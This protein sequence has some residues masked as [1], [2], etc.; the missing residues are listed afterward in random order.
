MKKICFFV[1]PSLT[2]LSSLLP[3]PLSATVIH[4]D[5]DDS[6]VADT[7]T[8]DSFCTLREA[9]LAANEDSNAGDDDCETGSGDDE[10]ILLAGTYTLALPSTDEDLNAD[11]DLDITANLTITGAGADV[12][13]IDGGGIDR[14]FHIDPASAGITVS[15][16]GL[17]VTG[18]KSRLGFSGGGFLIND[19]TVNLDEMNV[20]GNTTSDG[21]NGPIG[22]SGGCGGGIAVNAATLTLTKSTISNNTTGNGGFGTDPAFGF[23][24]GGGFGGGLCVLGASTLTLNNDTLSGNK[25]GNGGGG[26]LI[27]GSGGPGGGIA[28]FA[29]SLTLNN[30]TVTENSTGT[31]PSAL[32]G[33]GP[34]GGVLQ[35]VTGTLSLRNTILANN[36]VGSG[37]SGPDCNGSVTSN[38]FNLLGDN[39]GC[40]FSGT[41][42]VNGDDVGTGGSPIDP[43]LGILQDNGGPTETHALEVGSPAVDTGD[44]A[45]CETTD[46]RGDSRP[47]DGDLSGTSICDKGSFELGRC[48][49]NVVQPN[50]ECDDGN[51]MDGDGCSAACLT[52]G[53]GTTGGTGGTTGGTGGDEGGGG[54]SLIHSGAVLFMENP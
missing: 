43:K 46:Q 9:I 10:I 21:G 22:G 52:E 11:G 12:T 36:T 7:I 23:G 4:V 15:I 53:G 18:G 41:D 26:M 47:A 29:G 28:L 35:G 6:V 30:V 31:G 33:G 48:G 1:L 49:D 39:T 40:T 51:T 38:G 27:S 32:L 34:G 24:G 5:G 16:S 50:E 42:G 8:N 44:D 19:G 2:I 13:T 37:G 3:L 17:T 25:T 20:S 45:T 14:V 54:C